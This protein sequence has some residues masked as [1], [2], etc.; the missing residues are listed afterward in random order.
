LSLNR[1]GVSV[2]YLQMYSWGVSPFSV[3]GASR[4]CSRHEGFQVPA[5]LIVAIVV[6]APNGCS[7]QRPVYPLDLAVG[8][9]MIG[10]GQLVLDAMRTAAQVKHVGSHSTRSG[11]RR[12]AA[13]G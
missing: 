13:A 9:G 8:P 3:R 5:E 10:L 7:L 1:S 11:L 6:I 4:S 12:I 2:Q